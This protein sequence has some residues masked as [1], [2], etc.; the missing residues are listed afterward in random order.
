MTASL[1]TAAWWLFG[2]ATIALLV[3]VLRD[4]TEPGA[5]PRYFHAR[6]Y[7]RAGLARH[8]VRPAETSLSA[9]ET[10]PDPVVSPFAPKVA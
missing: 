5:I 6:R 7:H 8:A 10:V 3:A 9:L 1:I 2:A 4:S